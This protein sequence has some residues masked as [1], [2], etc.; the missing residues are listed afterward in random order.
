MK[1]NQY[2]LKFVLLLLGVFFVFSCKEKTHKNEQIK[3]APQEILY[4]TTGFIERLD[5]AINSIIPEDAKIEV[6][7][8]T[9]EWAEGP[10]WIEEKK[11]LL[12]SDVL[13]NKIYRWSEQNGM[14]L[15]LDHSGFTGDTT[16]SRERGSNGL[17]L[18]AKGNLVLCQHGDR[19][20]AQMTTDIEHP[21]STFKTLVSHY[22]QKR[23]NSPN[24]LV[25]DS[26]GN[27]YFTDPPYGLS[28]EMM[29]DP[30]KELSFQGVYKLS[31]DGNL[32]LLSDQISRPNGL[33]FSPDET[34]LYVANTDGENAA[35]VS[36]P[37]LEDG[38]LGAPEEIL[39][40]T[41]LIGK[42]VG[43]P[44]GIKVDDKGNI[45]TA[46]PGGLWIFNEDFKLMGKIKPNE[47]VSNLSLIHISEPT[48][49]Y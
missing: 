34:K 27:L 38:S 45:F 20:V 17:I 40:V 6:L 24:D 33:A 29:N 31:I 35:W 28:K 7:S 25:Y 12:C 36:F 4:K 26:K 30:K 8:D 5:P 43:Y 19:R 32:S 21:T 18:D 22:D 9:L 44:D 3:D 13:E 42:E 14:E 39:N 10:L 49:P 2:I 37:V 16:D 11:W 15:Y 23:L 46:G 48:R 41:Q 1:E 47:W